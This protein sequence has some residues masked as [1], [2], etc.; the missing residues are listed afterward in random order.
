M[1]FAGQDVWRTPRAY[2]VRDAYAYGLPKYG[3]PTTVRRAEVAKA[4]FGGF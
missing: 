4:Y 1:L 2:E 3:F